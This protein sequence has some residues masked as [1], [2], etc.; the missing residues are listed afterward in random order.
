MEAASWITTGAGS[1]QNSQDLQTSTSF[2]KPLLS[3]T[4]I[5][6]IPTN[7]APASMDAA[8]SRSTGTGTTGAASEQNSQDLTAGPFEKPTSQLFISTGIFPSLANSTT[9]DSSMESHSV[10]IQ[11]TISS[12]GNIS[13]DFEATGCS[14]EAVL[15][16]SDIC[17]PTDAGGGPAYAAA[18]QGF[19]SVDPVMVSAA[20]DCGYYRGQEVV[21]DY[22]SA[23]T[24]IHQQEN[25]D[26]GS[27]GCQNTVIRH[28]V[29]AP[30]TDEGTVQ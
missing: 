28:M 26:D 21:I 22:S 8:A 9:P 24:F 11:D 29:Q 16:H 20:D 30:I 1:E 7:S 4:R 15:R 23:G 13:A 27:L 25:N 14:G 2:E 12:Q 3:S 10:T 17:R 6:P 19:L 5:Y 18:S